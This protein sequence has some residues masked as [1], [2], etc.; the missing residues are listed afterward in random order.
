MALAFSYAGLLTNEGVNVSL[1]LG[2]VSFLVGIFGGL[3]W[4]FS[5]EKAAR[6]EG[7]IEAPIDVPK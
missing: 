6:G 4:I 7:P 3:V 2:A 5:P 1:V